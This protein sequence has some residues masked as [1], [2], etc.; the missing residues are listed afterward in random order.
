MVNRGKADAAAVEGLK[1]LADERRVEVVDEVLDA[2]GYRDDG[3]GGPFRMLAWDEAR[4]M[5]SDGLVSLHPH[6]VTHPILARCGDDKVER[7]ITVSCA[8]LE[9]EPGASQWF[10]LTPTGD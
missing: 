6:S 8:T 7:E 2:L 4:D 9:R 10:S 5:A 1:T 3:D